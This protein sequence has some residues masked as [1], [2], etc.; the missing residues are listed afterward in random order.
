MMTR[1]FSWSVARAAGVIL[2]AAA[3]P[4]VRAELLVGFDVTGRAGNQLAETGTV[5][6]ANLQTGSPYIRITRSVV[7]ASAAGSSFTSTGWTTNG[8]ST[9]AT[10]IASNTYVTVRL[11]PASGYTLT[12]TNFGVRAQRS[13][14]GPTNMTMRS[15]VDNFASDLLTYTNPTTAGD[16]SGAIAGVAAVTGVEFRIYGYKAGASGGT[17]RSP[18]DGG[19]FGSAGVDLAFFGTVDLIPGDPEIAVSGNGV[20]IA[21][22]DATPSTADHTDFGD[23][24]LVDGT[25]SRTFTI[26]NTGTDVLG[27]GTVTTAGTHAADFVVTAQPGDSIAVGGAATFTVQFDPSAVGLRTASLSVTNDDPDENPFNFSIQGTG[28]GA[29]ISNAPTSLSFLT[30]VG[31][32]P[33]DQSFGFTNV[34]LGTLN[35]TLSTNVPWLTVTPASGSLAAGAGDTITVS[36]DGSTFTAGTSNATVTITDAAATNS[37]KTVAVSVTISAGA[38]A[39]SVSSPTATGIG[40]TTA[41]LGGTVDSTNGASVTERGVFWSTSSGFTPPGAG[42]KVNESGSFGDGAFTL[43]VASLPAGTTIYYRPYASN[44]AGATYVAQD[45]FVTIPHVAALQAADQLS[46]TTVRANWGADTTGTTNYQIDVATDAGFTSYVN[47]Y[48]DRLVGL[49]NSLTVTGLSPVT[50]YHIRIRAQGVGGTS[51]NSASVSATTSAD[52]PTVTTDAVTPTGTTTASGG[53]NVTADGGAAVTAR[54]VCWN[55]TGSPTTADPATTNGTGTG[56]FSSTLTGLTPGQLYYVRAYAVNS[57]GTGYGNEQTVTADCFGSGPTGLFA[58]PT[59]GQNFTANWSA[60]PATTGYRLDVS[61]TNTFGSAGV[62]SS[63]FFSEYIEGSSNN[64]YVEIYNG[65]GASVDL[66]T[67]RVLVFINGSPTPSSTITLSGTLTNGGTYIVAN[68]AATLGPITTNVSTS[69]LNFNGDDAVALT[70]TLGG[71]YVDVIGQIG[72]DPG[73]EWGSGLNSTADNTLRRRPTVTAGDSNGA[74]AFTA[75]TNE[76]EGFASDTAGGMGNHTFTPADQPSF[77]AGYSNRAVAGTSQAVTGLVQGVTYYY[78]VRAEGAA[79]CVS[80]NSST[81]A[82]TT[83]VSTPAVTFNAATAT[84]QSETN[85]AFTVSIQVT[86]SAD[87]TV[88]VASVGSALLD[89]DF[90]LSATQF[91]F[92]SGGSTS[93]VLTI[94]PLDDTEIESAEVISLNLT[95][96]QGGIAGL[97]TNF[98]AMLLDVEPAVKFATAAASVQED[99]GT[100]DLVIQKTFPVNNVSGELWISGTAADGSDYTIATTNFTLTGATTQS[101][102][103]VT[104]VN[105]GT[106]EFAETVAFSLTNLTFAS[107]GTPRTL[108]LTINDDSDGPSLAR[109]DLALIGFHSTDPDDFAFVALTNL[110]GGALVKFT[111]NAWGPSGLSNNEAT[112]SWLTP[113]GG[114][115]AGTVVT[116]T[117]ST[118]NVGT[119]SGGFSGLAT[120][121]DQI[122]AYQGPSTNPV[123][124]YALNNQ[125][126]ATWQATVGSTSDSLLPDGLT[127]GL[128][129][130]ALNEAAN[131]V[132]TNGMNGDKVSL[133]SAIGTPGNWLMSGTRATI[134]FPAGPFTV[135][136]PAP[137]IAVRGTNGAFIADGDVTPSIADGTDFNAVDVLSGLSDMTYTI[138]NS[139]ALSLTV[140]NPTISGAHAADFSIFANPSSPLASGEAT[141][142]TVRFNPSATGLRQA[143]IE[144]GNNDADEQPYTFDVQGTGTLGSVNAS[145]VTSAFTTNEAGGSIA[146]QIQLS[147]AADAT[148]QV[149]VIGGGA[150]EG[151]DYTIASTQLVYELAGVRTQSL[152]LA[153]LDDT[154]LEGSESVTVRVVRAFGATVTSPSNFVATITDNEPTVNFTIASTTVT[155]NAGTFDVTVYKSAALN[156][157]SG[158]L[159]V[160]GTA[161]IASD[162]TLSASSFTL[163]GGTTSATITVTLV[164]DLHIEDPETLL[165]TLTNLT[166]AYTGA[167]KTVTAT[168]NDDDL[169][170]AMNAGDVAVIARFN[171]SPD[172]FS[173]L[174]LTNVV[175]G[176]RLY[177][178]DNGWDGTQYRGASLT[179]G[180]GTENSLL[181]LTFNTNITAGTIIQSTNDANPS[182]TFTRSGAIPGGSGESFSH[183][184]F[185]VGGDQCMVFQALYTNPLVNVSSNIY[186]HDDTAGHENAVGSDSG[187]APPGLSSNAYTAVALNLGSYAFISLGSPAYLESLTKPQWLAYIANPA[188]WITNATGSQPTGTL[189]V[190]TDVTGPEMAVLG[191]NGATIA[192]GDAV[193]AVADGTDFGTNLVSSGLADRIF[194][195]TNSGVDTLTLTNPLTIAGAHAADF[196]VQ[197]APAATVA[198][199]AT[200]TFTLRFDPT[201][202]GARTATVS[203]ANN[204]ANENP[205]VFTVRGVGE[206]DPLPTVSFSASASNVLENA[207]SIAVDVAIS[208]S[209]AA[210]VQVAIASGASA[211]LNL[212]YSLS[213]TQFVFVTAG[214]TSFT[215]TVSITN[216]AT[217]ESLESANL[218]LRNLRGLTAG[219]PTNFTLSI[220]DDDAPAGLNAG[221]L[222]IIGRINNGSPDSFALLALTNIAAGQVVYFT[223]NGYSN[224]AFRGAGLDGDGNEQ[225]LRLTFNSAVGAGTI[226]RTLDTAD[227][228]WTWTT[229]GSIPFGGTATF[230]SLSLG[231]SGEQIYGF[232]AAVLTTNPLGSASSHVFVLDDSAGFENAVDSGTGNTPAGLSSNAYTA[233]SFNFASDNVIG[234][235]MTKAGTNTFTTKAEWLAY[236]ADVANWTTASTGLPSGGVSFG[237]T[238]DAGRPPVMVSLGDRTATVGSSLTFT[239][240]AHDPTCLGPALS[241]TG[242]PSGAAFSY[243]PF[244]SNSLGT[245]TWTPGISQTGVHLVRFV[246]TDSQPLSTSQNIRVYVRSVGE[247]TNAFGVPASQTNWAVPITNIFFGSSGNVTV[248]W[249]AVAGVTY[250]LYR[251]QNSFGAGM[252]W[253]K[254]LANDLAA[255]SL[256]EALA[257]GGAT[258][259]FFQVVPAGFSPNSNGLWGLIKPYIR[260]NAF[261]LLAPPLR[262]DRAFNGEFGSSLAAVLTGNNDGVANENGDEVFFLKPDGSWENLYVDAAGT[263]RDSGGAAATNVLRTGQGV[264]VQR[265]SG[266]AAQPSF[267]GQ[268]GNLSQHTNVIAEGWNILGLSEGRLLPMNTLFSDLPA[269][270]LNASF[271]EESADLLIVL[272]ADGSWTRYQR[273]GDNQWYNLETLVVSTITLR[274]GQAYYFYRVSGTGSL[275]VRF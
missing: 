192:H 167:T 260:G 219:S 257:N 150:T 22:G 139:G 42:T 44:S 178:T 248:Q 172:T 173:L 145:L 75:A 256:E 84:S 17:A 203:I 2:L 263:W 25:L 60:V 4:V 118:A 79:S 71:G 211:S 200:T 266:A 149:A 107:T 34:G 142:F 76:W 165:I 176:Q 234:L 97:I 78:R 85:S 45:S 249:G 106:A 123:F 182:W 120:G 31:N 89:S 88:Q 151:A 190:V 258:Q 33:A 242:L 155:E 246:A 264:L 223:D 189:S 163:N 30:T 250:D 109:G 197:S 87:A 220:I 91:V 83:V 40:S 50:T 1:I 116:I 73:T 229:S 52:A 240:L 259:Q 112:V 239:F 63:L 221:D 121:G 243:T 37:P 130:V 184:N 131:G 3:A 8:A 255:G 28:K 205:Y 46:N 81:A 103:T 67:Y 105:D 94:T 86:L 127:N 41:T 133:L 191:T 128:T 24:G 13:A 224:A 9:I 201:A 21:D 254:V 251:S 188:N 206:A 16:R 202:L 195:I 153:L 47:G 102:V 98:S 62:A 74:D 159:T 69:S 104:V 19:A 114:V 18:A 261:T 269:G 134:T 144:I 26:T 77:V 238:C 68:N 171:G 101:L 35:Y 54:G 193:P 217:I 175:Q 265:N 132:Y 199:G 146:F 241:A 253:T 232:Q 137:E 20:D 158:D 90:S 32:S 113:G 204:D 244:G 152:S 209:G 154:T 95:N 230:G 5:V 236:I 156:N 157:V 53:G 39:P 92:T 164:N 29:G 141:T 72:T 210:T 6:A 99:V 160:G 119:S 218:Q 66:T 143:T 126:A 179:D 198:A 216:D 181:R 208:Y 274:P 58:N 70:N 231:Q 138:T 23:V 64:K 147:T 38:A 215:M 186:M 166:E 275:Q 43:S 185:N 212:D 207:G 27:L 187:A 100:Y 235:D 273:M 225:L 233:L 93:Q 213:A 161:L 183:P 272:D 268:V 80:P 177:F 228:R 247:T 162:F 108:T 10:A 168:L 61:T 222:A 122:L 136:D 174:L 115:A 252:S 12:V 14:S 15:S 49:V 82:V 262:S 48:Q 124:I 125:G 51:T 227:A 196:S 36:V 245:F 271:S 169:A 148:V 57:A 237:V 214:A 111:D 110:P 55:T 170:P 194:T 135:T 270:T 59:N 180:D 65:T 140:T 267:V 56:A 129:A 226:L 7:A 96:Y 117:G 11:A